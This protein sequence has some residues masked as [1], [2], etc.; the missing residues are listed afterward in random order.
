MNYEQIVGV[1]RAKPAILEEGKCSPF[2]IASL[3]QIL[4]N[5]SVAIAQNSNFDILKSIDE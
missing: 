2:F 5:F 4:A 3:T 1:W